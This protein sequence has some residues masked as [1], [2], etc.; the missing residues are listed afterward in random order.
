MYVEKYFYC[1]LIGSKG[2]AHLN[3]LCKWSKNTFS[4]RKRKFPSGPP[5]EKVFSV[6]SSDPTWKRE[7]LFFKNLIKSK[8]KTSFKRDLILNSCLYNLRKSIR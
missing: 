3:S 2:S 1:D 6:K 8:A 4:Y 7:Y 5:K